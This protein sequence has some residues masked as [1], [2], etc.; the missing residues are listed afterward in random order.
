MTQTIHKPSGDDPEFQTETMTYAHCQHC[1]RWFRTHLS[2]ATVQEFELA[3]IKK[4]TRTCPYCRRAM[5]VRKEHLRFDEVR[6]DGRITH[7]EGRYFL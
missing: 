4:S 7:T 1:G 2:F 5:E 6:I 3:R